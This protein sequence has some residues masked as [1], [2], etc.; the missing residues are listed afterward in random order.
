M[1]T[2]IKI[3]LISALCGLMIYSP[4]SFTADKNVQGQT[5]QQKNVAQT[6]QQ[7]HKT[8]KPRARK[9]HHPKVGLKVPSLPKNHMQIHVNKELYHHHNGTFYRPH[10][11]GKFIVVRPPLGAKIKY[12]PLGFI[13]FY[14]GNMRY[15]YLNHTYYWW[16]NVGLFYVVI[17]KP[18]GAKEAIIEVSEASSQVFAYPNSKQSE[19]QQE[20]DRFECYVWAVEQTGYDPVDL[21]AGSEQAND[22]RRAVSACLEARDYTVK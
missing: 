4:A 10:N 16:D 21:V 22:Y 12:L 14:I 1:K 15:F 2:P 3:I 13:S 11:R 7:M 20:Q 18:D 9:I 8:V 5:Q 19:E 6:K 17:D